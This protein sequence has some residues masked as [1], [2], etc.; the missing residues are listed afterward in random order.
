[1]LRRFESDLVVTDASLEID[2]WIKGKNCPDRPK[3]GI[4]VAGSFREAPPTP[5]TEL[6]RFFF[7][8]QEWRDREGKLEKLHSVLLKQ[9]GKSYILKRS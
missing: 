3:L 7:N 5:V 8:G 2:I 1:M 6:R 4:V 9:D